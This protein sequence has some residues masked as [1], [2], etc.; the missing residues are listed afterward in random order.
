MVH[1]LANNKKGY[2]MKIANKYLLC[3]SVIALFTKTTAIQQSVELPC[4][5]PIFEGFTARGAQYL[6]ASSSPAPSQ[7]KDNLK[8]L[9]DLAMQQLQAEEN[10]T[11]LACSAYYSDCY[12]SGV[13][14]LKP[15]PND[16]DYQL[17]SEEFNTAGSKYLSELYNR[18]NEHPLTQLDA[19][20]IRLFKRSA[21]ANSSPIQAS[22]P[23]EQVSDTSKRSPIMV[24]T[25]SPSPAESNSVPIS[26]ANA[27]IVS[28]NKPQT[29]EGNS[30]GRIE[31]MH[32]APRKKI[33]EKTS[34]LS[35][36]ARKE[37]VTD[38]AKRVAQKKTE[39]KLLTASKSVQKKDVASAAK[40]VLPKRK[41]EE[42]SSSYFRK[43]KSKNTTVSSVCFPRVLHDNSPESEV[44]QKPLSVTFPVERPRGIMRSLKRKP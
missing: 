36:T 2:E 41:R 37:A 39:K 27:E 40:S 25:F 18:T 26:E 13:P 15:L 22:S 33:R 12:S 11:R 1:F 21:S 24:Q 43:K 7:A 9:A 32:K 14:P 31:V 19:Y 28:P 30:A 3:A 38:K 4:Q 42:E 5:T 35:E 44:A 6:T 29:V 8:L 10:L 34:A 23:V 17:K 16:R 20:C